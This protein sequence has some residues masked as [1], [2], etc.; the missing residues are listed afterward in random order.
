[1]QVDEGPI[2]I[3]VVVIIIHKKLCRQS[4]YIALVLRSTAYHAGAE[5]RRIT[6]PPTVIPSEAL[7]N[8]DWCMYQYGRLI[9]FLNDLFV[10]SFGRSLLRSLPAFFRPQLKVTAT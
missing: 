3:D 9:L 4:F 6:I 2:H 1:M 10:R 8:Y 7:L 5:V